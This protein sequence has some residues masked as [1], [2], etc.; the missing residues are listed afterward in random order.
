MILLPLL[1]ACAAGTGADSN[2]D[3]DGGDGGVDS[4]TAGD[5]AGAVDDTWPYERLSSYG[6]FEGDLADL[7]PADGVLPYDVVARLWSDGAGKSRFFVLPADGQATWTDR[8]DILLPDGS[9]VIKSF[10]FTR[11]ERQPD[12]ARHHVE[13]RLLVRVDGTWEPQIYVWNEDQTEAY[14]DV[15]GSRVVVDR[16]DG[17]G[18]ELAQEYVIPNSNQ[19][20]GCHARSDEF[21]LLGPDSRQLDMQVERDGATVGQLEWLETQGFWT[22]PPPSEREAFVDPFGDGPLDQRARSYLH[23]NCSH[24]HRAGGGGGSSGLVLQAE[25]TDMSK[26]GVCKT[27]VA[28]GS[29]TGGHTYDIVP[30]DPDASIMAFRMASTDPEIKMPELPNLLVD[31]QGL[32][33]IRSW[34][35]AMDGSCGE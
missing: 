18:A 26:V 7:S 2:G 32:A 20:E 23:A 19:C 28:A 1:L 25:E 10:W 35:T 8:D 6:F 31:D 21:H 22:E 13:T 16:I 33:L 34:I 9:V 4:A 14:R 27:S 17:D 3:S 11:D 5:S 15:A 12:G 30:G 29:G 24:C